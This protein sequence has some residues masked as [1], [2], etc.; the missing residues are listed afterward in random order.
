MSLFLG[1]VDNRFHFFA[2]RSWRRA[3]VL[4][5]FRVGQLHFLP[6]GME[7]GGGPLTLV[8]F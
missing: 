8:D 7:G 5:F 1:E 3:L 2:A 6:A 4:A